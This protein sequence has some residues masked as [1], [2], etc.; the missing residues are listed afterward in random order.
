MRP[1]PDSS[2]SWVAP[3]LAAALTMS[4]CLPAAAQDAPSDRKSGSTYS[5]FLDNDVLLFGADNEDRNYTM[6]LALDASGPWIADSPLSAPRRWADRLLGAQSLHEALRGGDGEVAHGLQLGVTAFTPDRLDIAEPQPDDRP[7]ASLLYFIGRQQSVNP[8]QTHAFTSELSLGVLGL[9][10]ADWFQ[11]WLHEKMQE[12][13]GD[14]PF[15]PQGWHLQ[16]SDGGEPTARY[17]ARWQRLIGCHRLAD[18]QWVGELH[19]GYYTNAAAGAAVRI[20]RIRSP[21]YGF[22]ATPIGERHMLN[23]A[24]SAAADPCRSGS[25]GDSEVYVWSGAMAR[26]WVYN[27]LLRGQF[28]DAPVTVSSGR[29]RRL[30]AEYQVGITATF[31]TRRTRQSLTYAYARRSPEFGGP[32]RRYHSW[33]GLYYSLSFRG[34]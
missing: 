17:G 15:I 32:Q 8:A 5:V 16:I 9:S 29:L 7:Y 25:A 22:N 27:V 26:A 23:F 14:T 18:A 24:S 21:W 33:G 13:P 2:W 12:S 30:V 6:G 31:V 4:M 11:S 1:P 19:A 20:G 10:I 28:R 3:A 34:R